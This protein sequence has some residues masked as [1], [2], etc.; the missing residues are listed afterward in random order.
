MVFSGSRASAPSVVA[1]SKPTEAEKRQHQPEAQAAARHA[2]Q[3][4]LFGIE[5]E[6]VAKQHERTP[7]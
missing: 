7:R 4:Q 2:A 6:A 3:V 5:M 1:L